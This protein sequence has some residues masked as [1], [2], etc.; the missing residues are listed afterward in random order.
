MD[1]ESVDLL[2]VQLPKTTQISTEQYLTH[3]MTAGSN[4]KSCLAKC[5]ADK[6]FDSSFHNGFQQVLKKSK[7]P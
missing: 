4:L 7:A 1:L 6:I 5:M 2:D 3:N